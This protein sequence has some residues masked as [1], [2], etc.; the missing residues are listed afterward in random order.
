MVAIEQI[1]RDPKKQL[2][3]GSVT[4]AGAALGLALV[5]SAQ[6]D[7]IE[8]YTAGLGQSLNPNILF[9]LDM[10][11][12]MKRD[13]NG[14]QT[15]SSGLPSRISILKTAVEQL[16]D[17]NAN[18]INAGI[19]VFRDRPSG[20]LWPVSPLNEYANSVDPAIPVDDALRSKDVIMSLLNDQWVGSATATV[21]ALAEAALYFRGGNVEVGGVDTTQTVHF[22]PNVWD[23]STNRYDH[24]RYYA[25]NP[26]TYTPEDAYKT[27]QSS[28][29]TGW[30]RDYSLGGTISGENQCAG[31]A[32]VSCVF[33]QAASGTNADGPYNYAASNKCITDEQDTWEGADY[34]SPISQSCQSNFVVLISDGQPTSKQMPDLNPLISHSAN[35]CDNLSSSIFG[36][37]S[38]TSDEGNCGP[39]LVAAMH[40]NDQ[41][42]GVDNSNVSTYTIGFSVSGPGQDYLK[43]LATKGGGEFFAANQADELTDALDSIVSEIL[44][45]SENFTELSIDVNKATVSHDNRLFFSLFSP[46]GSQSWKGN[47]KGY[48]LDSEGIK[49]VNNVLATETDANGTRFVDTAQSFWSAT[50]D[51]NEV[52]DGGVAAKLATATRTLYTYTGGSLPAS[53]VSLY[54]TDG[55]NDLKTANTNLTSAMLGITGGATERAEL[56][57]WMQTA[58]MGDP[59][60]TRSTTVKYPGQ[61]V[62]YTMTNQGLLHAIDATL[63][64][65]PATA[66]T[67]GGDELFAFMPPELLSNIAR[68][69]N[70]TA[71]GAHIYGLDGG[72][73]RWHDDDNNN[74]IVD[75]SETVMLIFGMRRGGKNYYALDVTDPDDPVYKWNILGG[76]APFDK[77]AQSWSRMSLV[78]VQK[79]SATERVLMFGGGYD[80]ALDGTTSRTAAEGNTIYMVDGDGALIW[81]ASD[82]NMTY[83]MAAD[84]TVIDSD[85][86]HIADRVYAADLG[87]QVWRVDFGDVESS[88]GFTINRLADLGDGVAQPFF[89]APSVA[90]QKSFGESFMSVTLGS[91]N[92]THPLDSTSQNR[93]FMVKDKNTDSG[94]PP[95]AAAMITD[96]DLYDATSNDAG[97]SDSTT[98]A[99]AQ[100]DLDDADG[101]YIDLPAGEKSL[102]RVVS[103]EGRILATTFAPAAGGLS[104]NNCQV[105]TSVGRY[106][107]MGASDAR[108]VEALSSDGS[109]SY[110][111]TDDR[112]MEISTT[113]I[114]GAPVIVFPP[115]GDAV[116]VIVDKQSVQTIT[117]QLQH[118]YWFPRE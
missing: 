68:I 113:G 16:L 111:S 75:G 88:S 94:P 83:S 10:S 118:V 65:G 104:G 67:G 89:Y 42:P 24:G 55:A 108:P 25:P 96:S 12:S 97:S 71:L 102:S 18:K 19:S 80:E 29:S 45:G 1:M 31:K 85:N 93:F 32:I 63:P 23:T 47:L 76:Q 57:D 82:L 109:S 56:L 3:R 40:D 110:L 62:V 41:L 11:G 52:A 8:V 43:L 44:G 51:G 6:A 70:K 117:Q 64:V 27:G 30:C 78:T 106:Y 49:D 58:P 26:V 103:F 14:D 73:T 74:G 79:G 98:A 20:I 48:Y 7:D 50:A 53:G 2:S 114:P 39:E 22:K 105:T 87:G 9:V 46:S 28:G 86:D 59:L 15:S 72:M 60:H 84:L 107:A 90:L 101:W 115:G 21:G 35:T 34:L 100:S 61:T 66:D 13:V 91:G 36:S 116:Q 33:Q 17:Q 54:R 5:T 95:S 37:S 77:L 38:E 69:K 92:R 99:A 81:S 112:S 4:L